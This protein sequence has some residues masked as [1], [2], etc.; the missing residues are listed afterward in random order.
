MLCKPGIRITR[1]RSLHGEGEQSR[2]VPYSAAWACGS[3]LAR[4]QSYI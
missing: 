1:P 4:S 2:R 3:R